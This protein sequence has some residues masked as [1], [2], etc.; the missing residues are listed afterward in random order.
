MLIAPNLPLWQPF[1]HR[2]GTQ[3]I[4]H[5]GKDIGQG[6]RPYGIGH[7][8]Y[9]I[10][11]GTYGRDIGQGHKALWHMASKPAPEHGAEPLRITHNDTGIFDYLL[12]AINNH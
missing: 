10:G 3:G 7:G 11:H 4:W 8:T 2:P 6:H 1:G 12:V 5:I 9:G